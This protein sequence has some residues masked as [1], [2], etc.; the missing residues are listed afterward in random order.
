MQDP[1]TEV[2]DVVEE[3]LLARQQWLFSPARPLVERFGHAFFRA[4]P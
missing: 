3:A 2:D 1:V 4:L